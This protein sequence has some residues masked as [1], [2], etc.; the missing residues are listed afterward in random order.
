MQPGSF[1]CC[2]DAQVG[3]GDD[4]V[5]NVPTETLSSSS[6]APVEL[7]LEEESDVTG[8]TDVVRNSDSSPTRVREAKAPVVEKEPD[9]DPAAVAEEEPAPAVV[10]EPQESE[11]RPDMQKQVAE[12][13]AEAERMMAETNALVFECGYST[14]PVQF[15][16]FQSVVCLICAPVA[17]DAPGD[18]RRS[19]REDMVEFLAKH[20]E[21]TLADWTRTSAWSR[22]TGGARD[23]GGAPKRAQGGKWRA[24]F[25]KAQDELAARPVDSRTVLIGALQGRG[26]PL[27]WWFALVLAPGASH[28]V[29]PGDRVGERV[30]KVSSYSC[31]RRH[32]FNLP[33]SYAGLPG[34]R[35]M[36]SVLGRSTAQTTARIAGC[37]CLVS[38][39]KFG[40]A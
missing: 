7:K 19:I 11:P 35:S 38:D 10:P 28:V 14:V 24:L 29:S 40:A 12:D 8:Q 37:D 34:V 9:V 32:T 6:P 16:A 39:A 4:G 15:R 17:V 21:G 20:P 33:C 27:V 18:V 31:V 26:L 36:L 13:E 22:D 5:D 30:R 23:R 2:P 25:H 3:E 1:T